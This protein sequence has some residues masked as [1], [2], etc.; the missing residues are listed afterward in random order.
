MT[1]KIYTLKYQ[2]KKYR[3]IKNQP[4][5][6]FE[7]VMTLFD[8]SLDSEISSTHIFLLRQVNL[9]NSIASS[10]RIYFLV[11]NSPVLLFLHNSSIII[12]HLFKILSYERIE[13]ITLAKSR[14][15]R[16]ASGSFSAWQELPI[17][18]KYYRIFPRYFLSPK[19]ITIKAGI[20]LP[21]L[22]CFCL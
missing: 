20:F 8:A 15:L 16:I 10:R 21:H 7:Y 3:S 13:R 14:F 12:I 5:H 9:M 1:I 11:Y 6:I 2:S 18:R 4:I 19:R 17:I 22:F